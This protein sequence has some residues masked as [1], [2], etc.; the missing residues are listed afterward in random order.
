[1]RVML[2]RSLVTGLATHTHS[3]GLQCGATAQAGS[4]LT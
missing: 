1:M 3:E 2:V 4:V